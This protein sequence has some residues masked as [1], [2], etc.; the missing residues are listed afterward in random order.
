[1]GVEGGHIRQR[2]RRS[3]D[4]IA[5]RAVEGRIGYLGHDL[6]PLSDVLS[7]ALAEPARG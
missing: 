4:R 3:R 7:F 6:A 2:L 5:G 1:M